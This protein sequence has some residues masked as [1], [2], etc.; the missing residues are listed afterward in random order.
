M[1]VTGRAR[2]PFNSAWFYRKGRKRPQLHKKVITSDVDL[3]Y[4]VVLGDWW[5]PA[6]S[7]QNIALSLVA[8]VG[9]VAAAVK[10][11]ML[12]FTAH[13]PVIKYQ[14]VFTATLPITGPV[15]TTTCTIPATTVGNTLLVFASYWQS[16]GVAPTPSI[17]DGS[18]TYTEQAV[19]HATSDAAVSL[20][21]YTAPVTT[22][23]T[24]IT[25]TFTGS[26]A[27]NIPNGVVIYELTNLPAGALGFFA[28][29]AQDAG[30]NTWDLPAINTT[31]YNLLIGGFTFVAGANN[32][33]TAGSGWTLGPFFTA[34][35]F[36]TQEINTVQGTKLPGSHTLSISSTNTDDTAAIGVSI[37][38]TGERAGAPTAISSAVTTFKGKMLILVATIAMAAT[39]LRRIA[40]NRVATTS[41]TASVI[42]KLVLLKTATTNLVGDVKKNIKVVRTAA[43]TMAA[44]V[45]KQAGF[46]RV[47]TTAMTAARRTAAGFNRV[48]TTTMASNVLKAIGLKREA[49]TTMTALAAKAVGLARAATTTIAAAVTAIINGGSATLQLTLQATTAMAAAISKQITL[50]RIAT[51][52]MLSSVA[53]ALV[54]PFTTTTV[55]A[56]T[57]AKTAGLTRTSSLTMAAAVSRAVGL[58]REAFTTMSA[59]LLKAVTLFRSATTDLQALIDVIHTGVV[60]LVL[61]LVA[62]VNVTTTVA[63]SLFQQ[64]ADLVGGGFRKRKRKKR[65][66]QEIAELEQAVAERL[67]EVVAEERRAVAERLRALALAEIEA[68]RT[69][70]QIAGDL[71]S[72][73]TRVF[74]TE[75][76]QLE[77]LKQL[78]A[79]AVAKLKKR[80]REEE[81]ILLSLLKAFGL[82]RG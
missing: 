14:E 71:K 31:A 47:A 59:T 21:C 82:R 57:A 50:P 26:G 30:V 69:A 7:V 40:F 74:L 6:G 56:A 15:A 33:Y 52:T 12:D 16:G 62:T 24:S 1:A 55:M 5:W 45:A 66:A 37:K 22:S 36:G 34:S 8:T 23:V 10:K 51:T 65:V 38:G 53:K 64:L 20:V 3:A 25:L 67:P 79:E 44:N 28:N 60:N 27:A 42:R 35:G 43:S 32:T 39:Q 29:T 41:M 75:Q 80:R 77:T 13:P 58:G 68:K 9:M 78:Q 48:A 76:F 70:E 4:G 81:F 19:V 73:L 2:D 46:T 63:L 54:R 17:T 18:N 61:N 49:T 72:E 11:I